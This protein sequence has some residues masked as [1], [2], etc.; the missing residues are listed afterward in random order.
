M[1]PPFCLKLNYLAFVESGFWVQLPVIFLKLHV[2]PVF[3]CSFFCSTSPPPP[4]LV[5]IKLENC[6]TR[7]LNECSGHQFEDVKLK[8]GLSMGFISCW[9][10][11]QYDS[12]GTFG[13][14][15]TS[16]G[17][18]ASLWP[19]NAVSSSD[20]WQWPQ[21]LATVYKAMAKPLSGLIN[22]SNAQM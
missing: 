19:H 18:E 15:V 7:E 13:W 8:D 12:Q 3:G 5:D 9:P 2:K 4:P 10:Q 6:V 14:F 22:S 20:M 11:R 21:A 1:Y 17:L 16:E